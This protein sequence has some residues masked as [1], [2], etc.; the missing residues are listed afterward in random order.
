M[1]APVNTT[2]IKESKQ[3]DVNRNQL[4]GVKT[5]QAK[6]TKVEMPQDGPSQAATASGTVTEGQ[7]ESMTADERQMASGADAAGQMNRITSEAS[8]MMRQARQE[9]MLAAAKRGLGNSSIAAGSAQAAATKAALPLAQQTAANEQ[10][11]AIANQAAA[12]RA[13][14]MNMTEANKMEALNTQQANQANLQDASEQNKMTMQYDENAFKAAVTNATE[15]NKS[16]MQKFSG[17]QEIMQTWL[18]GEISKNLA[19]LNG[20]Y[21][22]VITAD[23][24]A[25]QMYGNTLDSL[26]QMWANPDVPMKKQLAFAN[27]AMNFLEGG[28][29]VTASITNMDFKTTMPG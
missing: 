16:A 26:A 24:V 28:L 27:S 9:G 29:K 11:Q 20:Q 8:P 7:A 23:Q 10:Q 18:S 5:K 13:S 6:T 12:N 14:E 4:G 17:D 22:Q 25:A 1:A 3:S 19:H 15:Q 21:Q 2:E